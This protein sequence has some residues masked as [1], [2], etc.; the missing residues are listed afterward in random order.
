MFQLLARIDE[1][2][3]NNILFLRLAMEQIVSI[4]DVEHQLAFEAA[5]DYGWKL[6]NR[7]SHAT[8]HQ[9]IAKVMPPNPTEDNFYAIIKLIDLWQISLRSQKKLEEMERILLAGLRRFETTAPHLRR[10][11]VFS[12]DPVLDIMEFLVVFYRDCKQD[13]E[14]MESWKTRYKNYFDLNYNHAF[15]RMVLGFGIG[16]FGLSFGRLRME[17]WHPRDT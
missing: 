10:F 16:P 11:W 5:H 8:I 15:H 1:D 4:L 12:N 14:N 3:A 13:P 7:N 2:E 9:L 6:F 17:F